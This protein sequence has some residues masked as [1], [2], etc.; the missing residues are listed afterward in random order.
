MRSVKSSTTV[1]YVLANLVSLET[2]SH[3]ALVFLPLLLLYQFQLLQIHVSPHPVDLSLNVEMWAAILHVL[4]YQS[5]KE[6]LLI[7]NQSAVLMQNVQVIWLVLKR[8]VETLAQDHVVLELFVMLLIIHL[9]AFAQ[10]VI[11]A[12]LS[13]IVSKNLHNKKLQSK[14][15]FVIHHLADL[16]HSVTMASVLVCQNIKVIHIEDVDQSVYSI[17]TAPKIELVLTINVRIPVLV[18]VVRMQYV[19][20]QIIFQFAGALKKCLVTHLFSVEL[21]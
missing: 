11:L 4:A 6:H 1:Q 9:Y 19:K 16:M 7:V 17:Q 8:N 21:R 20:L 5:T 18:H 10:R 3:F 14:K 13:L 12:I 15:I 2:H